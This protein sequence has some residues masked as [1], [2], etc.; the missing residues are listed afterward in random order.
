[1]LVVFEWLRDKLSVLLELSYS[2]GEGFDCP[3]GESLVPV[4]CEATASCVK[5]KKNG[6]GGV[7]VV[8]KGREQ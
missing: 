1:V 6:W 8:Q 5:G 2:I 7:S 3:A 4:G